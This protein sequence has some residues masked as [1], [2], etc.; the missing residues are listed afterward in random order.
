[1]FF[2]ESLRNS[3]RAGKSRPLGVSRLRRAAARTRISAARRI[4]S[5]A[6]SHRTCR[7]RSPRHGRGLLKLLRFQVYAERRTYGPPAPYPA[8]AVI[9]RAGAHKSHVL[10]R[11]PARGICSCCFPGGSRVRSLT[12]RRRELRCLQ[13]PCRTAP[14]LYSPQPVGWPHFASPFWLRALGKLRA[15]RQVTCAQRSPLKTLSST[16][17]PNAN[18]SAIPLSPDN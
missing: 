16:R 12:I 2:L 14:L 8:H 10:E 15:K 11:R 9:T 17:L 7:R 3:R 4:P 18:G 1:M 5:A 6:L 13:M